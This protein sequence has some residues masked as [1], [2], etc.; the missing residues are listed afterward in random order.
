MTDKFDTIRAALREVVS[1]GT[2]HA[3]MDALN[4][5]EKTYG[6]VGSQFQQE[7]IRALETHPAPGF[8]QDKLE[9]VMIWVN[10]NQVAIR[11]GLALLAG[12]TYEQILKQQIEVFLKQRCPNT[13]DMLER[14]EPLPTVGGMGVAV[15]SAE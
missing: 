10:T 13:P 9:E 12:V 11:L 6:T 4:E 5:L 15:E 3:A 1:I 14:D 7:A 2:R 8:G